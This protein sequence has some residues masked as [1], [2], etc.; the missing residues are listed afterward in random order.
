MLDYKITEKLKPNQELIKMLDNFKYKT[1]LGKV[2]MIL[3]TNLQIV[4]PT[5]YLIISPTTLTILEYK[6]NEINNKPFYI[7]EYKNKYSLS[8]IKTILKKLQF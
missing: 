1:K 8:E 3:H 7:K 4:E 6:V 5:E 2:K